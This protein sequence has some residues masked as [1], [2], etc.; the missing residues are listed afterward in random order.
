M[1][2][3]NYQLN[4]IGE[5]HQKFVKFNAN[6]KKFFRQAFETQENLG[7]FMKVL[8]NARQL[9]WM[10]GHS[11][12]ILASTEDFVD[13]LTKSPASDTHKATEARGYL[14]ALTI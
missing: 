3:V 11:I 2:A 4:K 14:Q 6:Y 8:I 9:Y 5:L 7:N 12:G 1:S 10:L 13:M